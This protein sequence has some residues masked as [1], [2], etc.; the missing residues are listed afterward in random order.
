MKKEDV[1]QD[2]Q[3]FKDRVIRDVMY[4]VDEDGHYTPVISDGW[5]VKNDALT[6]VW[7]DIREQCGEIRR[8]VLAQQASP[9]A[10]HMKMAL[11]DVALLASYAGVPKRTVRRH[12]KYGEFM[13]ADRD[14]LQK[15]A[16]ALR[17]TVEDLKQVDEWK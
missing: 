4:A 10:Y 9:L 2:L 8:Q 12:L 17:I 6:A 5:Q 11:Q 14:T 3:F 15:Y 16:D 13:K 7:D 1:P